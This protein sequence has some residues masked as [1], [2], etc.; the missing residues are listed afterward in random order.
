MAKGPAP[1]Y[2]SFLNSEKIKDVITPIDIGDD[3]DDIQSVI[4]LSEDL[5]DIKSPALTASIKALSPPASIRS[6]KS[7]KSTRSEDRRSNDRR[8]EDRRSEDRRSD[9][10]RSNDRRSERSNDRR[11]EKSSIVKVHDDYEHPPIYE[12][13]SD[14]ERLRE[15]QNKRRQDKLFDQCQR[16]EKK[17]VRFS[18]KIHADTPVPVMERELRLAKRNRKIDRNVKFASGSM[19]WMTKFME[20]LSTYTVFDLDGWS[21]EFRQ[22]QH[23]VEEIFEELYEE[24]EEQFDKL[25]NPFM[26]LA[27]IWMGGAVKVAATNMGPKYVG[28]FL[29]NK[30]RNNEADNEQD[31]LEEDAE[32]EA[33]VAEAANL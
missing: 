19:F 6:H 18:I 21:D 3:L 1:G 28:K 27:T 14:A 8:S 31:E 15:W 23:E 13:N 4:A 16:M 32:L 20:W 22:D 5:P 2:G 24:H 11:S 10:R 12:Q 26:K 7:H 30:K 17:G 33:L 9:D 25:N 29:G